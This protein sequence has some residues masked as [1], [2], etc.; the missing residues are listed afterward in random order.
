MNLLETAERI[1]PYLCR[2]L[3]RKSNGQ[4][5]LTTREIAERSG[6]SKTKVAVLS[7]KKSWAGVSIDEVQSFSAGCGVNLMNTWA[8]KNFLKT[9]K[10]ALLNNCNANQRRL[11]AKLIA[12][13]R[14]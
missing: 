4:H 14:G 8:Q 1:P 11:Y 3:A 7:L 13:G 5:P 6:L 2:F 10:K 12:L 9:C